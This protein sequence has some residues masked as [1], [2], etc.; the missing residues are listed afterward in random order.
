MKKIYNVLEIHVKIFPCE[1]MIRTSGEQPV[2]E[3]DKFDNV[4]EDIFS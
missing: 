3:V 1:D 2:F 4:M